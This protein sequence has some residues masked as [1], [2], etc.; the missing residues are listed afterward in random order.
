MTAAKVNIRVYRTPLA[1]IHFPFIEA[2]TNGGEEES[3]KS[4]EDLA[5]SARWNVEILQ[6][7]A[8]PNAKIEF[9]DPPALHTELSED[10]QVEFWKHYNEVK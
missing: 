3:H 2:A 7:N 9:T 5:R 6:R 8:V 1:D 10:E 4:I